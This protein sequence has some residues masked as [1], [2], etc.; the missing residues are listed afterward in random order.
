MFA[1][2]EWKT[3][4]LQETINVLSELYHKKTQCSV[5]IVY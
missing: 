3:L 2:N 4:H 5:H 1:K